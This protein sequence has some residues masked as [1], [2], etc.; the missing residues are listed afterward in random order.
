MTKAD[1][2]ESIAKHEQP[3]FID[4]QSEVSEASTILTCKK[5]TILVREGQ[6]SDK[7]ISSLMD[8]QEP[9]I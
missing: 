2:L 5:A 6:Y 7:Q 8:V 1:I 3:L 4:C 9:M